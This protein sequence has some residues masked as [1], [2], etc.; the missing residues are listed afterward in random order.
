[1][2]VSSV[3]ELSLQ[4]NS[5]AGNVIWWELEL[6]NY[7]SDILSGGMLTPCPTSS[8]PGTW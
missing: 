5:Q 8:T 4:K 1:M 6:I 3:G 7:I 2:Y